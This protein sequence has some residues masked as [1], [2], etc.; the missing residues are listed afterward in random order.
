MLRSLSSQNLIR[1]IFKGHYVVVDNILSGSPLHK[2]EIAEHLAKGGVVCCWSAMSYHELTD[3]V[4]SRVY[5]YTP[6]EKGKTRSLYR[7]KIEGY[8]F[9]LIQTHLDHLWGVERKRIG[10]FK[11]RITD[12]ERT[13]MDG[14][15]HT[16]YC[17]GFREVLSA[18]EIAAGR[19]D[20]KK[21][22][23]YSRKTSLVAQKRL[24]WILEKLSLETPELIEIP[25]KRYYDKLDPAGPRRGK[26]NKKW[27]V[28]ENF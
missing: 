14:L 5:V 7:Y 27:M 21:L 28:I 15:T 8:D 10:E 23:A 22:I 26:Y 3:H 24:G 1:Q 2:F 25:E 18:F 16:H 11:I 17:G 20:I 19:M 9:I 12:L 13:L 6:Q 4:L